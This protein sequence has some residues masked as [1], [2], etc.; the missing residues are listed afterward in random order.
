VNIDVVCDKVWPSWRSVI[1]HYSKSNS[2]HVTST[3]SPSNIARTQVSSNNITHTEKSVENTSAQQPTLATATNKKSEA[4]EQVDEPPIRKKKSA[5]KGKK[6]EQQQQHHSPSV[7]PKGRAD[8]DFSFP[9]I[10]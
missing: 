7:V 4:D 6:V 2:R 3:N 9:T 5:G 10:R 1:T 8:N